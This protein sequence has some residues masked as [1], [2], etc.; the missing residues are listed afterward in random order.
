MTSR[1]VSSRVRTGSGRLSL[2]GLMLVACTASDGGHGS[3]AYHLAAITVPALEASVAWYETNLDF[4]VQAELTGR[5]D[6][7]SVVLLARDGFILEIAHHQ[8]QIAISDFVNPPPHRP[9]VQGIFKFGLPVASFDSVIA[10][11]RQR[12]VVFVGSVFEDPTFAVRSV[13]IE[14]NSGIGV[15]L[16]ER[17]AR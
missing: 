7:N 6:K 17:S 1:P 5:D 4:D 10:V 16:F 12:G 15:Q 2:L 13:V 9:L 3:T 11:L 14:D 8:D